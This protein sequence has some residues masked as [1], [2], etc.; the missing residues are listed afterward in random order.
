MLNIR[1]LMSGLLT[2]GAF[3]VFGIILLSMPNDNIGLTHLLG[4]LF[5]VTPL[6]SGGLWLISMSGKFK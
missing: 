5:I 2:L 1:T 4:W 6:L 3:F